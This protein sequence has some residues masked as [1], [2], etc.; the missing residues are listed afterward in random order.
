MTK[1][2]LYEKVGY[3][4]G[5]AAANL[6]WR[7]ALAY[8]AVFYTDTFGI[9]A[10]AAAVLF[11]IVRLSDGITDIIMG[12]IADRTQTRYGKFRPWILWST[13]LLGLFMVLCFTTPNFG[14]QGKLVWAYVTYLGLTLAYT[15]NNVPYSA[16][17]GVMTADDRERTSLSGFRFAG[18]F[19]GG[20][21]VMGFLPEFVAYFGEGDDAI[22]YQYTMYVFAAALIALMVITFAT[23]K[24]RVTVSNEKQQPFKQELSDLA[25]SL[26]FIIL[27]LAAI[28][29][30]FYYRDLQ[31]AL[32][33]ALVMS[34]LFFGIRKLLSKPRD[35]LSSSQLDL[36]DLLTNKPW[37]ILLGIGF[38]SMM[39]NGIKYGV[40]AYYFKY[41]VGDE[42]MVGQ[43]F[44]A[45]LVVSI[46]G[47]LATSQLA[48]WFGRKTL[49]IASL[50][51]SGVLTAAMFLI[52]VSNASAVFALG[53]AAEFFAAILPTLYFS[54][55][56]D[57]ADYSEWKNHR[58]ATGLVY[59]AGT[60]VQK[61]GGGF[62]G[63]L[64]LLVLAGYGY[65][66]MDQSTIEGALP[67][68]Q[69]L[70]SW[71]P[72]LFAFAGAILMAFYPI[73]DKIQAQI[74][75]ELQ[76]RRA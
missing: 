15:L 29:L 60:F 55:L 68:I 21:F 12:M 49:F 4:M 17:M 73:T 45:L 33:F 48:K 74:S 10:A 75:Q 71:I 41:Y 35:S 32:F 56:G 22:G 11:L 6:V 61:T 64:V 47:A 20:L 44:V 2:P 18:A 31:T 30:F 51:L 37:L 46:L 27:P 8:L 59:S 23:T 26:P 16:L 67:G 24:E 7:G 38:I 19:L 70:M 52:P 65:D 58:R 13:P 62:A 42:L 66:G 34:A 25:K 1:L 28:S 9:S 57:S 40:I 63:A 53:C 50:L 69:H 54:M 36:A 43:Y 5:D 76:S 72:A 14:E 3:A 39:F